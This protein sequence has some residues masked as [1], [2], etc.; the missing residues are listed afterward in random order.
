MI[1]EKR[2]SNAASGAKES[3]TTTTATDKQQERLQKMINSRKSQQQKNRPPPPP[4][5]PDMSVNVSA[6][7]Q[8]DDTTTG[9]IIG[10][11]ASSQPPP[12]PMQQ[13]KSAQRGRRHHSPQVRATRAYRLNTSGPVTPGAAKSTK[14]KASGTNELTFKPKIRPLPAG[15]YGGGTPDASGKSRNSD[16]SFDERTAR[17]VIER[18]TKL[19]EKRAAKKDKELDGCT[20]NPS[21]NVNSR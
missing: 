15:I 1:Q 17:A 18:E 6:I 16:L 2:N 20:F 14:G 19:H 4:Q 10:M 13:Q 12:P 11:P 5:P 21:I 3:S 9:S 8:A 7:N